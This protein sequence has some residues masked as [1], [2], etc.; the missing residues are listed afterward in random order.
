MIVLRVVVCQEWVVDYWMTRGAPAEKLVVGMAFYGKSFTLRSAAKHGVGDP[1][2]GTGIQGPFTKQPGFMAYF[3][4]CTVD[5]T[6]N[7][8]L[9]GGSGEVICASIVMCASIGIYASIVICA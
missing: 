4:V 2:S 1:K 8:T 5:G 9:G 6:L 3:E 7:T